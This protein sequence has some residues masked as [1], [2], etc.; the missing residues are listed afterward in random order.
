M[1]IDEVLIRW[2]VFILVAWLW[3]YVV[4]FPLSVV[5]HEG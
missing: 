3:L 2:S 1:S 4:I 5:E